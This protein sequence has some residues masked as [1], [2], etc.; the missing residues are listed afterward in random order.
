MRK[1]Y[2][3]RYTKK[4]SLVKTIKRVMHSEAEHKFASVQGSAS[5]TAAAIVA[6]SDIG[7]GDLDT[8][9]DG[10]ELIIRS[11]EW[12]WF[13]YS[14]T[15]TNPGTVARVILFQWHPRIAGG[16]VPTT[17][18]VLQDTTNWFTSPYTHDTKSEY[19][20]LH[21]SNLICHDSTTYN[22]LHQL[23]RTIIRSKFSK[24]MRFEAGGTDGY[25]KIY[26]LFASTDVTYPIGLY[27]N[28][29]VNFID[30]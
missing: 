3:K 18:S 28:L 23:K 1:L 19:T 30:A 6:L 8:T 10:D 14:Q 29:K 2:K 13:S 15:L 21:D 27:Y 25:N 7:Q 11:L 9:R 24:K 22:R 5:L 12:R 20:I 16:A 17:A 4:P 26:C